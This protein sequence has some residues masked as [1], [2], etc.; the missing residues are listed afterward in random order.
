MS[1]CNRIILAASIAVCFAGCSKDRATAVLAEPRNVV[2]I[3]IDACRADALSCYGHPRSTTP[4]ID[5]LA[6]KG[7]LFENAITPATSTLPSHCSILTGTT[8]PFHGVHADENYRLPQL[9]VTLAETLKAKGFATGAVVGSAA[10]DSMFGLTQGFDTYDDD[11]G[12]TSGGRRSAE[13]V[14]DSALAWLQEHAAERLFLLIN[15]QDTAAPY[16]PPETYRAQH[17]GNAYLGE[18]SYTDAQIGRVVDKLDSLGLTDSTLLIVTG[19]HGEGTGKH[20]ESRHGFFVYHDTT[21]VPL[22]VKAPGAAMGTRIE[23]K[24]GLIDIVPTVLSLMRVTDAPPVHGSDLSPYLSGKKT[25][26]PGRY[27]YS[28]SLLP[29]DSGCNALLAIEDQSWKYIQSKRPELY[30]LARDPGE[31]NNL[32]A[33]QPNRARA[34]QK[35]LQEELATTIRTS[36]KGEAFSGGAGAIAFE[37]GMEDPKDFIRSHDML[38]M[39]RDL[40][41]QGDRNGV[42]MMCNS[43][44]K[45]R[46]DMSRAHELLGAATRFE[47]PDKR[48][49]HFLDALRHDPRSAV[50]HF[51]LGNLYWKN[52]EFP[53]AEAQF[54]KARWLAEGNAV[55]DGSIIKM[56][57]SF[58]LVP[59]LRFNTRLHL[60]DTLHIQR[61]FEAAVEMYYSALYLSPLVKDTPYFRETKALAFLN[62]GEN[63]YFLN[64][65]DDSINAYQ[66]ALSL[67]PGSE[68]AQRG[69]AQALTALDVLG[70]VEERLEK[71]DDQP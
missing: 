16:A 46:P 50:A 70:T 36:E 15:Y 28:E 47:Q 21:R 53:A 45:I 69:I 18:L 55:P 68:K 14:T 20:S 9:N 65:F 60:A 57:T 7:V 4:R 2:L 39:T 27:F 26:Y 59:P 40:F 61:K 63:L 25:A 62:L 52:H 41:A 37:T 51:S 49:R 24:V 56:L 35:R 6:R 31:T 44:L 54:Q 1:S 67:D 23:E 30:D 12:S 3:T 22:I 10:L 19:A 58:G 11:F 32:F 5:A 43:I 33:E 71:E 17:E 13:S 8:P 42:V 38:L 64:R 66:D 48:R 29:T 34:F